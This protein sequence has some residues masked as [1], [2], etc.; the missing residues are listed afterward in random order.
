ML[1][2]AW[3]RWRLAVWTAR[4][5]VRRWEKACFDKNPHA[6]CWTTERCRKKDV[7]NHLRKAMFKVELLSAI[8]GAE[9]PP[10]TIVC[11]DRSD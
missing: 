10:A 7:A 2:K 5:K 11:E 9:L 4:I 1:I 6:T 3:Y 8:V